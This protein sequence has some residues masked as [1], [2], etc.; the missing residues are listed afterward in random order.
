[1]KKIEV[2][3]ENCSECLYLRQNQGTLECMHPNCNL[4]DP[5]DNIVAR[6]SELESG[7]KSLGGV[8]EWCPLEE[9]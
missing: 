3:V 7:E 5:W 1:M 4:G 6:I 8:P 9:E 2:Y